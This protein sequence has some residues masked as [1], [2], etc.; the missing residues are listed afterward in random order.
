LYVTRVVFGSINPFAADF[1]QCTYPNTGA[2]I[3]MFV[4]GAC[5]QGP[6]MVIDDELKNTI[7]SHHDIEKD[8][9]K[10]MKKAMKV[11]F[12]FLPVALLLT[13]CLYCQQ[14][15]MVSCV[16]NR[17]GTTIQIVIVDHA[18]KLNALH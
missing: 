6:G 3:M 18:E 7:R 12:P 8:N 17:L 4:G 5:T 2:R 1:L 10:Y 14:L 9:C 16:T 11:N 15:Q 13:F